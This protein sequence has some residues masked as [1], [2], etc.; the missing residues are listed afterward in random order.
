MRQKSGGASD[1]QS[2]LGKQRS[3][4]HSLPHRLLAFSISSP[5]SPHTRWRPGFAQALRSHTGQSYLVL[6][7]SFFLRVAEVFPNEA[8]ALRLVS[9]VLME[10]TQEWA[11]NRKDLTM[12]RA[13]PVCL[14]PEN[15]RE[16]DLHQPVSRG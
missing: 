3:Y 2:D 11:N 6:L 12:E 1:Y 9:A 5:Q 15:L 4:L 14:Q 10:I 8:S 7:A 13:R 16:R